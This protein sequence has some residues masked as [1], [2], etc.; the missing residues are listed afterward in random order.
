MNL[1]KEERYCVDHSKTE[2]IIEE[3]SH[4]MSEQRN[5]TDY[6]QTLYFNNLE[7]EVPFNLSIKARKYINNTTDRMIEFQKNDKW[8]FEIKED[9]IIANSRMRQKYRKETTF[10]EILSE[11]KT[12]E[13]L[14]NLPFTIPFHPYLSDSYRRR[15][16]VT[17]DKKGL[18]ITVDSQLKYYMFKDLLTAEQIGNENYDRIEIKIPQNKI[19]SLEV[20]KVKAI[21]NDPSIEMIVSKKDMAYNI[22]ASYRRR[23]ANRNVPSSNTEIEAKLS[24]DDKDQYVFHRIKNDIRNRNITGFRLIGNFDYTLEGAKIHSYLIAPDEDYLRVSTKGKTKTVIK[25]SNTEIATDKF[26]LN[27]IVKRNENRY[28]FTEDM[29]KFPSRILHRKRKYFLVESELTGNSFC[30]LVDRSICNT[31][32]IFQ[33]E[34]EGLAFSPSSR[35]EEQIVKDISYLTNQIVER[36]DVLKPTAQTKLEWLKTL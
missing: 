23:Q 8:I 36:Y 5:L 22:L 32:D 19:G 34:I 14:L 18:R 9:I 24:L 25:K 2:E 11:M 33:M 16:F 31:N 12:N 1:R 27:C 26:G 3:L 28:P 17:S 7:H 15:H 6:N 10:N 35:D 30:I 29:K 20:E 21:L 4:F 13:R